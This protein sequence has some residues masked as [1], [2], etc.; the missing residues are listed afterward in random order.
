MAQPP[1]NY[2]IQ[3]LAG[4]DKKAIIRFIKQ[5][6]IAS[7]AGYFKFEGND[8]AMY[9]LVYGSFAGYSEAQQALNNLD[10]EVRLH[11]TWIR[12]FASIHKSMIAEDNDQ[13]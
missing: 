13:H 3:L 1:G 2:T 4:A 9:G 6:K 10:S 8:T 7:E 12:D 5:K 11:S